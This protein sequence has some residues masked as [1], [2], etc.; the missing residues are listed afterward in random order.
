MRTSLPSIFND[1]FME[2]MNSLLEFPK[3]FKLYDDFTIGQKFDLEDKGDRYEMTVGVNK[4]NDQVEVELDKENRTLR[5]TIN[6]KETGSDA[7]WTKSY[8]GKYEATLPDDCDI[9]T[10]MEERTKDNSQIKV[11]IRKKVSDTECKRN[12]ENSENDSIEALKNELDALRNEN[13]QLREQI[14]FIESGNKK[15]SDYQANRINE[16]EAR[17]KELE[18]IV[19]KIKEMF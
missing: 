11:S 1:S 6:Q 2:T 9:D 5:V 8:Y 10:Y 7:S 16:L 15:S 17:N 12:S 18:K 14:K 3:K 4:E 19:S 13:K